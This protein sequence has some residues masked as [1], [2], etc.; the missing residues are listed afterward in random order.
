ME[1]LLR[2]GCTSLFRP[3]CLKVSNTKTVILWGG[4]VKVV[5]EKLK[6]LEQHVIKI[7]YDYEI[8]LANDIV[9]KS[10]SLRVEEGQE[11]SVQSRMSKRSKPASL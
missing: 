2:R 7:D 4:M 5:D 9:E 6:K 10:I 8:R 11:S 3:L 1:T